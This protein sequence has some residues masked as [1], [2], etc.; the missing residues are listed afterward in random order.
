LVQH[1]KLHGHAPTVCGI[2]NPFQDGRANSFSAVI[3]MHDEVTHSRILPILL[4]GNI[5]AWRAVA[6]QDAMW[7]RMPILFKESILRSLIPAAEL[8]NNCF[9]VTFVVRLACERGGRNPWLEK[10]R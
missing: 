1:A 2:N 8:A 3:R 6:N 5:A 10:L 9:V 4:H 7:C